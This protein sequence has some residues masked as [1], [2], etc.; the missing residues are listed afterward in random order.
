MFLFKR[1]KSFRPQ[2]R[3]YSTTIAKGPRAQFHHFNPSPSVMNSVMSHNGK[4]RR[5]DIFVVHP[6]FVFQFD[7][8]SHLPPFSSRTYSYSIFGWTGS[9]QLQ[10]EVRRFGANVRNVALSQNYAYNMETGKAFEADSERDI[11]NLLGI[12]FI[13]PSLRNL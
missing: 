4:K 8:Q 6:R 10:R 13:P 12:D 7:S 9:K 2:N 1:S 11:F 3:S 5:V